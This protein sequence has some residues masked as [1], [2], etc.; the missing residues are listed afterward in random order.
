MSS[1][2]NTQISSNQIFDIAN[3]VDESRLW[4]HHLRLATFGARGDGGVNRQALSDADTQARSELV[5][6]AEE[7]KYPCSIDPVGNFFIRRRGRSADLAPILTGSHLDTQPAGGKFDGAFGVLAALEA[8]HALDQ[9]GIETLRAIEVVSW[10]NEE[11]CRF[12]PGTMGSSLFS[13]TTQLQ[14]V[15]KIKDDAGMLFSDALASM[16]NELKH[17]PKRSLGFPVA[18]YIEAHIEQGPIM[19]RA[20]A[21]IGIV[22]GIQGA[23]WFEVRVVG[24]EGHAGTTPEVARHDALKTAISI[25]SSLYSVA[26]DPTDTLRFTVGRLLVEPNSPNTIPGCVVFSI[27]LRHPQAECLQMFGDQI[28]NLIKNFSGPSDVTVRETLSMSPVGFDTGLI[29]ILDQAS[30]QL[31]LP[32]MHLNS[33]AFHDA[34][35]MIGICPAAMIFIP[36]AEGISHNPRESASSSDIAAG[37]KVLAIALAELSQLDD[38]SLRQIQ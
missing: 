27:D 23:R 11:G 22:T 33:G 13:G 29:R 36:C 28:L 15:L 6:W 10:T 21:T 1:R 9:A 5:R 32:S 31:E 24:S 19:E 12:S 14:D 16:M 4:K 2:S 25:I 34:K 26:E 3:A 38:E 35:S 30:K 8:L 37:A 18:A 20:H 7:N 17:V